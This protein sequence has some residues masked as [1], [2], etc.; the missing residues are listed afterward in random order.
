M[1]FKTVQRPTATVI[2]LAG[3][4]DV[5]RSRAFETYL[6]TVTEKQ[7]QSIALDMSGLH[8][9]D[10]SGINVLTRA[11]KTIKDY[12][13]ALLLVGLSPSVVNILKFGAIDGFF[14][15]VTLDDFEKEHPPA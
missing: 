10:S 5:V 4:F 6:A 11:R 12:G 15:I 2:Q 1:E 3:R 14:R 8:Y 13:G 7:P 9:L